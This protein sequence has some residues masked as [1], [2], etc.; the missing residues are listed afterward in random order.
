VGFFFRKKNK[1]KKR[2]MTPQVAREFLKQIRAQPDITPTFLLSDGQIVAEFAL[3]YIHQR[4]LCQDKKQLTKK[5]NK[6]QKRKKTNNND[7]VT[8]NKEDKNQTTTKRCCK[9]R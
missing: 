3:A 9:K 8:S 1:K 7:A 5:Q 6:T 4:L 2:K